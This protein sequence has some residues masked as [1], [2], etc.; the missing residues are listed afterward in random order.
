MKTDKKILF[1]EM[2]EQGKTQKEAA[3]ALGVS[4][5][6]CRRWEQQA[7]AEL[8][9]DAENAKKVYSAHLDQKRSVLDTFA[10]LEKAIAEI[11]LDEL[12]TAQKLDLLLKYGRRLD[13]L[14]SK[15]STLPAETILQGLDELDSQTGAQTILA[16]QQRLY[17]MA[18]NGEITDEQA[19]KKIALLS[20]IRK[21]IDAADIF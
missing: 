13:D 19:R 7:R 4:D 8:D 3:A 6:T 18:A 12:T 15:R 5:R 16:M 10:K 20:E 17:N 21:T 2:R 9:K 14:D 11:D 1:Y